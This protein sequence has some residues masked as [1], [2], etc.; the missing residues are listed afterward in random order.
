MYLLIVGLI[1]SIAWFTF[2]VPGDIFSLIIPILVNALI[3]FATQWITSLGTK[4]FPKLKSL[5]VLLL[6]VPVADGIAT[7]VSTLL[8]G[9]GPEWYWRLLLGAMA[10]FADQIAKAFRNAS[11]ELQGVGARRKAA[12]LA[13]LGR[14]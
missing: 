14:G 13:R 2:Q 1:M 5:G 11:T 10:V 3:P 8:S 12:R 6:L 4:I 9:V 7:Y